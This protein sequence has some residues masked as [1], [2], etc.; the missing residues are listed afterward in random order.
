MHQ[1]A[2][3]HIL[4]PHSKRQMLTYLRPC[5]C[6]GHIQMTSLYAHIRRIQHG[7]HLARIWPCHIQFHI[8]D[9]V[10]ICF[11]RP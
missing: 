8:L 10:R 1:F 5:G 7:F 6:A 4:I 2:T 11:Y 3:E 9:M